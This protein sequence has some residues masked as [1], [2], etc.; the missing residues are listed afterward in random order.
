MPHER[1]SGEYILMNLNKVRN[2]ERPQEWFKNDATNR[3]E[4]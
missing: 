1:N 4:F 2:P 3:G